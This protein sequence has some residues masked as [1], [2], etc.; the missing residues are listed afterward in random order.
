MEKSRFFWLRISLLFLLSIS[1]TYGAFNLILSPDGHNLGLSVDWLRNSGFS[2]YLLPGLIL[3]LL[4]G[5]LPVIIAFLS[6]RK[7]RNYSFWISLQGAILIV[8]LC[9]Q[10]LISNKFFH[11]LMHSLC[12]FA[13]FLLLS[14]DLRS[15]QLNNNIGKSPRPKNKLK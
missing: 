8:W 9:I 1:A 13:G 7:V 15:K 4:M 2:N 14:S 5:L 12:F 11:P 3:L 10:L 6:L